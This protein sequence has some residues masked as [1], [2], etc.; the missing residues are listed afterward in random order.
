MK[1]AI[2]VSLGKRKPEPNPDRPH[3]AARST[4]PPSDARS[5]GAARQAASKG[6]TAEHGRAIPLTDLFWLI[7]AGLHSRANIHPV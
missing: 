3:W 2:T 5:M 7:E 1:I 4:A 6:K